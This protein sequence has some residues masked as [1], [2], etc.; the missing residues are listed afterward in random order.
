MSNQNVCREI[1][2][3]LKEANAMRA[4]GERGT[5]D[6]QHNFINA[7]ILSVFAS[8]PQTNS[9]QQPGHVHTQGADYTFTPLVIGWRRTT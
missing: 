6:P 7:N 8:E 4:V 9:L 2:E 5:F 1:K 3:K